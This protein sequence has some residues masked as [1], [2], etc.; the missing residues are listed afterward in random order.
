MNKKYQL[1][2]YKHYLF[3]RKNHQ[4]GFSMLEALAAIM[5]LSI[6]FAVNLQL[7][8]LLKIQSLNQEIK[9]GAIAVS[10]EILDDLRY[11]IKDSVDDLSYIDNT[12]S[13]D[14]KLGN[15]PNS[16][17]DKTSFGYS[18]DADVYL[19]TDEPTI[20]DANKVTSCPTADNDSTRYIV[21]QIF[22]KDKPNEKIY[23]VQTALTT[24][25]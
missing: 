5:I 9:T 23:T 15:T 24:V 4:K 8:M 22:K 11:Q 13:K 19:C 2:F 6:A 25:Q 18:Y 14:Y 21:V 7:L 20:D 12:T 1:I 16:L 3:S 17:K 10:K